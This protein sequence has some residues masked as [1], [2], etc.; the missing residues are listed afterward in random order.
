MNRSRNGKKVICAV[1]GK[2]FISAFPHEKYCCLE[3]R[4]TAQKRRIQDWHKM[5]PEYNRE[6]MRKYRKGQKAK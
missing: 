6:Y 4:D 2:E 3:C 1:C 5:H